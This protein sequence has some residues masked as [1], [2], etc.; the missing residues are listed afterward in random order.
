MIAEY[1]ISHIWRRQSCNHTQFRT[2]SHTIVYHVQD[3]TSLRPKT[4]PFPAAHPL[5]GHIREYPLPWEIQIRTCDQKIAGEVEQKDRETAFVLHLQKQL[6]V[7]VSNRI[8]QETYLISGLREGQTKLSMKRVT[9]HALLGFTY[10]FSPPWLSDGE[11]ENSEIFD[12]FRATIGKF[13]FRH[14]EQQCIHENLTWRHWIS[15]VR[16]WMLLICSLLLRSQYTVR[17]SV[18]NRKV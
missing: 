6:T 1:C 14:I 17:K 2:D 11:R 7:N 16:A 8:H 4:I 18:W 12:R 13:F 5:I 3:R 9:Q 10:L 15:K